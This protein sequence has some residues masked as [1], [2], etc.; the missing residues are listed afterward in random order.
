MNEEYLEEHLKE[1]NK[2]VTSKEYLEVELEENLKIHTKL[3]D[4][5]NYI[6]YE[7]SNNNKQV[8]A[9]IDENVLEI[10][11]DV[12]EKLFHKNNVDVDR[13]Y[14]I[15]IL[16]IYDMSFFVYNEN[17]KNNLLIND[18]YEL[19]KIDYKDYDIF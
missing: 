12:L 15:K 4:F 5:W 9:Y 10:Y 14:L 8:S 16:I 17:N 2:I 13:E 11:I 1:L 18:F 3:I 6:E 7:K 19:E